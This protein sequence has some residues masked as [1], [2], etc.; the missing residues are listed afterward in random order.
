MS[1]YLGDELR[2]R[3]FDK[4][5]KPDIFFDGDTPI[6]VDNWVHLS[7]TFV[8]WLIKH[9]YLTGEKLPVPNH[10]NRGKY[11]ISD[12]PCHE[13]P[14]KDADWQKINGFFVDTKYNADAHIKNILYALERLGVPRSLLRISIT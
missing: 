3:L 5:N 7:L 11:F 4:H 2:N 6:P 8:R 10:A 14:R 13:D 12:R 9:Q 1:T